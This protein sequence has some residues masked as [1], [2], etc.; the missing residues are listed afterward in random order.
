MIY[1]ESELPAALRHA[2]FCAWQFVMEPGDPSPVQ[3]SI[4]PDGTTNLVLL[5]EPSGALHGIIVGPSLA[6]AEVPVM[7][8]WEYGGLRLRP[9]AAERILGRAPAVGAHEAA[10]R[11]GALRLLW[12]DLEAFLTGTSDWLRAGA[13]LSTI[14]PPDPLVGAAVDALVVT[15]GT[16]PL[17]ALARSVGLSERQFRRRFQAATGIAPKFYADV[18]RARRALIM[19]LED[20]DWAGVAAEAG[21]ADQSHLVRDIRGRFGAPPRHVR[22][23]FRGIRHELVTPADGRFVQDQEAAAA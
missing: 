5:R 18:Q 7:Q 21:F 14:N 6:C 23:Y 3:H 8:G 10:C 16:A 11:N 13:F 4:P 19:A 22:G 1:R 12:N 15:G 9:E 20:G 2:A 17:A